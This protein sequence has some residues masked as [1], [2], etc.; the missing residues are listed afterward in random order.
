[1]PESKEI[2]QSRRSCSS[3]GQ[4]Q[5]PSSHLP[6]SFSLSLL[7]FRTTTHSH[8]HF[9]ESCLPLLTFSMA[10]RV[11][12][13]GVVEEIRAQLIDLMLWQSGTARSGRTLQLQRGSPSGS[14]KDLE[15]VTFPIRKGV[16]FH[17]EHYQKKKASFTLQTN[18][19]EQI[20]SLK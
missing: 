8:Q 2:K 9:S 13:L 10:L 20:H 11:P 7:R 19:L 3:N 18:F 15:R 6:D 16:R 1:M 5:D 12:L 14:W 4:R 17:M